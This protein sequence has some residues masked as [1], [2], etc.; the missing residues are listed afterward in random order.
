MKVELSAAVDWIVFFKLSSIA[1][2]CSK[3]SIAVVAQ[4]GDGEFLQDNWVSAHWDILHIFRCDSRW[5]VPPRYPWSIWRNL[6]KSRQN[7]IGP[8]LYD[9]NIFTPLQISVRSET[10]YFG[11]KRLCVRSDVQWGDGLVEGGEVSAKFRIKVRLNYFT[12]ISECANN[13]MTD[14][15]FARNLWAWEGTTSSNVRKV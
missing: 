6:V 4:L 12:N 7:Y 1:W 10:N 3:I 8:E 13:K 5:S 15:E 14:F 2:S 9:G 11:K